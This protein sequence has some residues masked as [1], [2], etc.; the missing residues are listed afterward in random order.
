MIDIDNDS[1]HTRCLSLCRSFPYRVRCSFRRCAL[2]SCALVYALCA[3]FVPFAANLK[4]KSVH[5]FRS[6]FHCRAAQRSFSS[7]S[8]AFSCCSPS[9]ARARGCFTFY[10]YAYNSIQFY[11]VS[12][13]DKIRWRCFIVWR[14]STRS[15]VCGRFLR[16][17]PFNFS[18]VL[19][20]LARLF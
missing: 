2:D 8:A 11:V 13:N 1:A 4:L 15:L 19:V 9:V 20:A 12:V 7:V 18:W 14:M 16:L 3:H 6:K 17:A 5:Q 10:W